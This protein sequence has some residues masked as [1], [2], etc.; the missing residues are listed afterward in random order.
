M[1][2][3]ILKFIISGLLCALIAYIIFII[4]FNIIHIYYLMSSIISLFLGTI[5][6]Y[7]LNTYWTFSNKTTYVNIVK[8]FILYTITTIISVIFLKIV[9]NFGINVNIGQVFAIGI[10]ATLNFI[11]LKLFVY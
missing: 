8:Y 11:S 10:S 3:Q 9:V 6:S 7:I 4:L 1:K 2:I 5:V